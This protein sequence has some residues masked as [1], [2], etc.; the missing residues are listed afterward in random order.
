MRDGYSLLQPEEGEGS[1]TAGQSLGKKTHLRS[2]QE[3]GS[4]LHKAE[5]SSEHSA[6]RDFIPGPAATAVPVHAGA[7]GSLSAAVPVHPRGNAPVRVAWRDREDE[8]E[9]EEDDVKTE[10]V[11]EGTGQAPRGVPRTRLCVVL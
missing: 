4:E 9:E 3:E 2:S 8:K 7:L 1:T 11:E 6:L 10:T 5:P